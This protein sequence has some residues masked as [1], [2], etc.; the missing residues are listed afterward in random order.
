MTNRRALGL[1]GAYLGGRSHLDKDTPD[2]HLTAAD[3]TRSTQEEQDLFV[4]SVGD[5]ADGKPKFPTTLA[6]WVKN[7]CCEAL[8]VGLLYGWEHYEPRMRAIREFERLT[9]EDPD[10]FPREKVYAWYEELKWRE[11]EDCREQYRGL[12][13]EA[14]RETL[15]KEQLRFYALAPGPDG[16]PYLRKSNVWM[17]DAADSWFQQRILPLLERQHSRTLWRLTHRGLGAAQGPRAP[18]VGGD[19]Y[20]A[21]NMLSPKE[22]ALSIREAPLDEDSK[23]YCWG[24]ATHCGCSKSASECSNSHK[25]WKAGTL[26]NSITWSRCSCIVGAGSGAGRSS[27]PGRSTPGTSS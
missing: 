25:P 18:K 6:Q 4:V 23:P 15:R 9:E 21:G 12:L 19:A 24:A 16:L 14:G 7:C 2:Y 11:I 1:S 22:Q 17:L 8:V 3:Y 27:P 20:P 10:T 5:K 26:G 13:R